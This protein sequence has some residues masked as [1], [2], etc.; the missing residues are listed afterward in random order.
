MSFDRRYRYRLS[1]C[2]NVTTD[3]TVCFIM[4]NPSTANAEQDDPT[5]RRCKAYALAWEYGRLEVVNLFAYRATDPGVL[6]TMSRD[7]AIGVDN[8]QHIV[9]ACTA[10]A[11]VVCAWG[12]HGSLHDRANK[13][14]S[15]IRAQSIQPHALK[16][17]SSGHPAHPLYLRKDATPVAI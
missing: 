4:L 12:N 9:E 14:L 5:I 11:L 1:R 2:V 10:S 16:L 3:D 6:Y 15:L 17:N 7:T 8:D 13:V